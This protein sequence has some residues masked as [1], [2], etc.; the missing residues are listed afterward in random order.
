MLKA[1]ERGCRF[2]S[3]ARG[4]GPNQAVIGCHLFP[5]HYKEMPES[6][7]KVLAMSE[8]RAHQNDSN[9]TPQHTDV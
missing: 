2:R 3:F 5:L 6:P 8:E 9:D 4:L 7:A 1:G